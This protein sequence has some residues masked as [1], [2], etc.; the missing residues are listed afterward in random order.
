MTGVRYDRESYRA[1]YTAGLVG[2]PNIAPPEIVDSLAWYSGYVEGKASRSSGALRF[3]RYKG[4]KSGVAG[5]E[6]SLN[7]PHDGKAKE[8]HHDRRRESNLDRIEQ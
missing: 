7:T 5:A 2:R 6:Y 3:R 1:G 8:I 4:L